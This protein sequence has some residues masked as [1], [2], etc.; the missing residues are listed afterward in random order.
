MTLVDLMNE[1]TRL[2]GLR[3]QAY[4]QT[5][6]CIAVGDHEGIKKNAKRLNLIS[7]K[8]LVVEDAIKDAIQ[9][10]QKLQSLL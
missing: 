2:I 7:K 9:A 5:H 1:K 4:S 10:S 8:I 6:F 3:N